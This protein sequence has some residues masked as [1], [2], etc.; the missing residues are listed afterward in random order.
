MWQNSEIL[1]R[2]NFELLLYAFKYACSL[3]EWIYS[4]QILGA[5]KKRRVHNITYKGGVYIS[6]IRAPERSE[7]PFRILG[8][9]KQPFRARDMQAESRRYV[10]GIIRARSSGRLCAAAKIPGDGPRGFQKTSRRDD[11]RSERSE[12]ARLVGALTV[13]VLL[14]FAVAPTRDPTLV[15]RTRDAWRLLTTG[16][17]GSTGGLARVE[18]SQ[19][20]LRLKRDERTPSV[21]ERGRR[22]G[23]SGCK[24]CGQRDRRAA[25]RRKKKAPDRIESIRG[26]SSE[27]SLH[28]TFSAF[29]I[30]L[31]RNWS[32]KNYRTNIVVQSYG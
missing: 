11:P 31:I 17:R 15:R 2:H 28:P 12:P 16:R 6:V 18:N 13:T 25:E 3:E 29:R 14:I 23:D 19:K 27:I 22:S 21:G 5:G 1:P 4:K 7:I 24:K 20:F 30:R 8:G 32:L 10:S 9:G 26:R